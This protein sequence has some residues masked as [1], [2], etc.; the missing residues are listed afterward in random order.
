MEGYNWDT[1]LT[2]LRDAISELK[3]G[4]RVYIYNSKILEE[5]KKEFNNLEIK[6]RDFYWSV[7]NNDKILKKIH[8]IY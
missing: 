4:H 2:C 6:K 5:V 7:K 1:E 8:K 3:R